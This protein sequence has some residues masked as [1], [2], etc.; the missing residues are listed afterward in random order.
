MSFIKKNFICKEK[1]GTVTKVKLVT[2]I[3]KLR[4]SSFILEL[5]YKHHIAIVEITQ[6]NTDF[7][8]KHWLQRKQQYGLRVMLIFH[9]N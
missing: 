7:L 3:K 9:N 2:K 4:K 5:W 1:S 8:S 6:K